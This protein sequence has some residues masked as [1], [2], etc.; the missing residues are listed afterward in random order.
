MTSTHKER[1]NNDNELV[2]KENIW[3][4]ANLFR[5]GKLSQGAF[6][7]PSLDP[8]HSTIDI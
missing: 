2:N 5:T 7:D 8:S 3:K 6:D 4:V 1:R